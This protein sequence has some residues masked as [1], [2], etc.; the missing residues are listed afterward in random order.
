MDE[1][2]DIYMSDLSKTLEPSYD[3]IPVLMSMIP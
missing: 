2:L 1:H 3:R